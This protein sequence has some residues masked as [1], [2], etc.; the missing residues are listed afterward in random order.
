MDPKVTFI[1]PCY[2]LAHFL[3]VCVNSIL[4]QTYTDFEVLILDDVSPDNT[5]EV[6]A[7]FKDPRVI[8]IRNETNL[9]NIRNYNKGIEL[10][11][12]R[13]IWL[14]SADD[15]LRSKHVLQKYVDI[16]EKNPQVGYVFCPAM[17]LRDGAEAGVEDWSNWP[18][19]QD[20]ILN[21]REVL[22]RSTTQCPVCA[23][24]GL[25]R[26][27]CYTRISDFLTSL[28]RS[29]DWYLWAVFAM[30]YDVGYFAEPMVYYRRHGANMDKVVEEE[31]PAAFHDEFLTVRWAITKAS[32][33]AGMQDVTSDFIRS[34]ADEYV[35]RIVETEVAGWQYGRTRETAKREILEC[36][37]SEA[38]AEEMLR[39]LH[40]RLPRA[41]AAKRSFMGALYYNQGKLDLAVAAFR[42]SLA[43]NPWSMRPRLYLAALKI[44]RSFGIRLVP[45]LKSL[46]GAIQ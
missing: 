42:S 17:T 2:K 14:I 23:P 15:C 7:E 11:R 46:K 8:Y 36:A 28:P 16:L 31:Q 32:E 4:A 22:K 25:V 13:Y 19:N 43:S 26:K 1:V 6:A 20:R 45:W 27:E 5:P 40:G 21:R 3:K 12:G 34:L 35:T 30:S 10:A 18:G 24:T 44:E 9:G 38:Q 29:S 41:L 37:S 33:K 39:M